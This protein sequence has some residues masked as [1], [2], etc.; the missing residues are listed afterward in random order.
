[1]VI[2][3][4]SKNLLLLII[5]IHSCNL[6]SQNLLNS[7]SWEVGSNIIPDYKNVGIQQENSREIGVGPHGTDVVLWKAAPSG[8][9]NADGGYESSYVPID[10]TKTYR[11]SVWIKKTNSYD[12]TA[13]F[14]LYSKDNNL[15]HS[16]LNLNN[17]AVG[18][19]YF[20]YG[21]LP[22]I[23]KWYLLVG[24]IHQSNYTSTVKI[25][26]IYDG[27]T[28]AKIA[29]VRDDFKFKTTATSL[30]NR[31]SLFY[32]P[33]ISD[34]QYFYNPRIEAI[35]GTEP[36]IDQLIAGETSTTDS[37]DN[38]T[39]SSLWTQDGNNIYY[40]TDGNVGIGVESSEIPADYKLAIAGKAIA[41]EVRIRLKANWPDYVFDKDYNL[42]SLNEIENHIMK[43]GHLINIPSATTVAK[44]GIQL[45]EMNAKLLEKIE[46]LT[47]YT[48]EQEKKL[49]I[50]EVINRK[51]EVSNQNLETKNKELEK[52]LS[53]IEILLEKNSTKK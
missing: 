40:N 28:G 48:I 47:L 13:Y 10:H 23:N 24:Y 12:G 46:E 39:V 14:G 26:G 9:G 17:A 43:K 2:L 45:G 30:L 11:L 22:N 50:Q 29:N 33:N 18:N 1:M 32:D 49:N 3:K 5:L 16:T 36:T 53:R 20:W 35:N 42:P 19:A 41:Q 31:A 21:D 7:S 8:D 34:N 27:S 52:R 51:I 15:A 44:D 37:P 6:F 25:G 4:K 38:T